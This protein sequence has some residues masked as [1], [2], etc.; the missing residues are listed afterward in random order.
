MFKKERH[1]HYNIVLPLIFTQRLINIASTEVLQVSMSK[2]RNLSLDDDNG[3]L[4][5]PE[6]F[7]ERKDL[8]L[9]FIGRKADLELEALQ[10]VRSFVEKYGLPQGKLIK[11][12]F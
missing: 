10:T 11:T 3:W 9:K 6:R 4:F 1:Q 5:K 7:H 2:I 8:L 12:P